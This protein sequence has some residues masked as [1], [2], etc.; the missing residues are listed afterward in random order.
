MPAMVVV[1]PSAATTAAPVPFDDALYGG[2]S[3][4]GAKAKSAKR[5]TESGKALPVKDAKAEKVMSIS[6]KAAKTEVLSVLTT[7]EGTSCAIA[8]AYVS[9]LVASD[10]MVGAVLMAEHVLGAA[11]PSLD[12]V[13]GPVETLNGATVKLAVSDAGAITLNTTKVTGAD[14]VPSRQRPRQRRSTPR[15]LLQSTPPKLRLSGGRH[16][17]Q[18]N[19]LLL[20]IRPSSHPD[21]FDL[22]RCPS[23]LASDREENRGEQQHCPRH[24]HGPVAPARKQ[25]RGSRCSSDHGGSGRPTDT[26]VVNPTEAAPVEPAMS[27]TSSALN[28]QAQISSPASSR[29]PTTPLPNAC[30]G[31]R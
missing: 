10:M 20:V 27:R 31:R 25:P 8:S 11:L 9:T 3:G 21:E 6:T 7:K 14:M 22:H 18:V 23:A 17:L 28:S 1:D 2:K 13:S 26:N 15:M 5:T 30:H 12:I 16:S 29:P 4:K 19:R 24:R